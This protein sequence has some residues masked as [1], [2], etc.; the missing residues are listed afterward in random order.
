MPNRACTVRPGRVGYE[1]HDEAAKLR[2]EMVVL[3]PLAPP[4]YG[5]MARVQLRNLSD[6]ARRVEVIAVVP[7]RSAEPD[8][9][10]DCR[11]SV[12]SSEQPALKRGDEAVPR[13]HRQ[14]HDRVADQ[15]SAHSRDW[16]NAASARPTTGTTRARSRY[17]L[18]ISQHVSET[19]VQP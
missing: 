17:S 1:L 13:M 12:R 3:M 5:C 18:R 11:R 19:S 15:R 10:A 9:R 14:A 6:E 8:D 16:K 4:A 7:G 2:V